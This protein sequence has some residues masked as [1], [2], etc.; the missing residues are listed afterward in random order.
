MLNQNNSTG[1]ITVILQGAVVF[2]KSLFGKC[3]L[4]NISRYLLAHALLMKVSPFLKKVSFKKLKD[5]RQATSTWNQRI[6]FYILVNGSI[7]N[8]TTVDRHPKY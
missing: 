6:I 1:M 7:A 3:S 8:I 2:H 5:R 4:N